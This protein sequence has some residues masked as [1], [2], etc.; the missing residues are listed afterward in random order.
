MSLILFEHAFLNWLR[1]C[2]VLRDHDHDR[3][4]CFLANDLGKC[5]RGFVIAPSTIK[6][7]TWWDANL[8]RLGRAAGV[9]PTPFLQFGSRVKSRVVKI[10][11]KLKFASPAARYCARVLGQPG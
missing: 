10:S 7:T 9:A 2:F 6:S 5:G 1:I 8:E 4:P 11:P 3:T